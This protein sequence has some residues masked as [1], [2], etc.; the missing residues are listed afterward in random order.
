ME[1]QRTGLI[2]G[3]LVIP[4]HGI[5]VGGLTMEDGRV[6][7]ID[8]PSKSSSDFDACVDADGRYVLPGLIDP[9]VHSGLLPPLSD[10]LRA[11]SV[12][13]LSGGVT[14]IVRYFRRLESYLESGDS[15]I[16]L[17]LQNSM[18]DFALHLALF[19]PEQVAEIQMYTSRFGV[20]SFKV[21]MNLGSGLGNNFLMDLTDVGADEVDTADV[22]Y[23]DG[24]LYDVMQ[25][26]ARVPAKVTVCIHA[27][28]AAI[29]A[30]EL[31]HVRAA[32]L[33]GLGAWSAGRPEVSEA[34]A[35][36]TAGALSRAFKVPIYFPH[37]GSRGAIE[38]LRLQRA[39]GTPF[40]AETC[41]HYV[42]LT[43]ESDCGV[44]AK[45]MPPVRPAGSSGAVWGAISEGLVSCLGS[46]HIAY[47]LVEKNP[48]SIWSTRPA[49][50]GTGLMF[51]VFLSE[52][53][54]TG[55]I[56]LVQ[57]ACLGSFNTAKVFGLYPTKGTLLPGSDA[58]FVVVGMGGERQ[59][60]AAA[61]LSA[62]DFSVYEGVSLRGSVDVVARH[63]VVVWENGKLT[64]E[65]V[66]AAYLRRYPR[67]ESVV[68]W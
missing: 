44:L 4:E 3:R 22:A 13:G 9:H 24:H 42:G 49:F 38:A 18:Q 20:T 50:G 19:R 68:K 61:L 54:I 27:E 45:V 23:D 63:G 16:S 1:T 51:P 39:L 10:R 37:I 12:F 11:E 48:G 58:D 66:N 56:S 17:S 64:G 40:V 8:V 62:S 35:I 21:Y 28:N 34:V 36:G 52:G 33:E 6:T 67:V 30:R 43:T 53:V 26:A 55:N 29:V 32:G 60:N 46:D 31:E 15:Q 41:A 2:N 5:I 25:A 47:R 57:L 7:S 65:S 14:T 59:V